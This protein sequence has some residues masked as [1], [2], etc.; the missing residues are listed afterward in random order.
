MDDKHKWTLELVVR[1][2]GNGTVNYL[3][4]TIVLIMDEIALGDSTIL[5]KP[6]HVC[7]ER[8]GVS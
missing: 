2:S 1:D 5:F 6:I 4:H 8:E 3:Q 7:T